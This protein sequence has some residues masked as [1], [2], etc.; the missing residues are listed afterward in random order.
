M[1]S[2]IITV[3]IVVVVLAALGYKLAVNAELAKN[4]A[5][6]PDASK[7]VI[8]KAYTVEEKELKYNF[9]YSGRFIANIVT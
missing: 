2:K 4:K 9:E 3:I 8:V 7:S 6:I 1:K 5:Y